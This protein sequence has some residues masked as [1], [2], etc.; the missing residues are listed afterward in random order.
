VTSKSA[1]ALPSDVYSRPLRRRNRPEPVLPARHGQSWEKLL[2]PWQRAAIQEARKL[3]EVDRREPPPKTQD[4]S[5]W[6]WSDWAKDED[7]A[8]D[9]D[10]DMWWPQQ[11][12]LPVRDDAAVL[13]AYRDLDD[14]FASLNDERARQSDAFAAKRR[15]VIDAAP[16]R[17]SADRP[18]GD[19]DDHRDG[20][21]RDRD[22]EATPNIVDDIAPDASARMDDV[23]EAPAPPPENGHPPPAESDAGLHSQ[24]DDEQNRDR[25]TTTIP[26]LSWEAHPPQSSP[27]PSSRR[28]DAY[29]DD[30]FECDDD[31]R[32]AA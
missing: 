2:H 21:L 26:T 16:R 27:V 3:K 10:D 28:E 7:P 9:D 14:C 4:M 19:D 30:D 12:E 6:H 31:N 32:D 22:V 20:L 1:P 8:A 15:T 23:D 17:T 5:A 29:D 13:G 11:R 18:S 24:Q 25:D